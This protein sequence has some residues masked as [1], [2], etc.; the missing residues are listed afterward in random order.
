MGAEVLILLSYS[1]ASDAVPGTAVTQRK[2]AWSFISGILTALA[3]ISH[4]VGRKGAMKS[5]LKCKICSLVYL[6][7][8]VEIWTVFGQLLIQP[9][10]FRIHLETGNYCVPLLDQFVLVHVQQPAAAVARTEIKYIQD[11]RWISLWL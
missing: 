9:G 2:R 6:L 7:K 5:Y 4:S 3:S 11:L 8:D 1:V 10:A